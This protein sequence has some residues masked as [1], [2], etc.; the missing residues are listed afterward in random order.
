MMFIFD[1]TNTL[2]YACLDR[3]RA[4]FRHENPIH[5]TIASSA[6]LIAFYLIYDK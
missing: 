4:N 3:P 6:S 5:L 1:S 2:L